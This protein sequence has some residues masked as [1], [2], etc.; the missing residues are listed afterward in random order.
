MRKFILILIVVA[1]P[2]IVSAQMG[3]RNNEV[4]SFKIAW[5][6]EKL[7][8]SA[9]DA[10]IF[11]PIYNSYQTEIHN[12]RRLSASKL[13]SNRKIVEINELSDTEVQS[14]ITSELDFKQRELNIEK[15]YNAKFRAALPIKTLAKFYRAQEAFKKELLN[16]YRPR[17]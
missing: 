6:T 7:D 3:G 1:A 11:W 5:I 2:F 4:E 8:L 14:L 16:R 12:L 15:K 10:K 13:I 9:E 17:S